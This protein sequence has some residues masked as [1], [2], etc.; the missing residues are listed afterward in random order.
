VVSHGSTGVRKQTNHPILF[1]TDITRVAYTP[2]PLSAVINV[3]S[4]PA[5]MYDVCFDTDKG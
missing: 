2:S 4:I 1:E 3:A 5:G